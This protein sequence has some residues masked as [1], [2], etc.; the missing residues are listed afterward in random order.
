MGLGT[1]SDYAPD[2]KEVEIKFA[3]SQD[4]HFFLSPPFFFISLLFFLS[5][6]LLSI[7]RR[8]CSDNISYVSQI[9]SSL[10][11]LSMSRLIFVSRI[12][13]FCWFQDFLLGF[14]FFM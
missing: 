1:E 10:R 13:F 11:S 3:S 4:N 6:C 7:S 14:L 8:L 12:A 5:F 9:R 2:E